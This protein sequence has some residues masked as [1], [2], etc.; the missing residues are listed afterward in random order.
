MK[1]ELILLASYVTSK[2]GTLNLLDLKLFPTRCR[3]TKQLK[4]S[5][6]ASKVNH[7]EQI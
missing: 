5:I 1:G 7:L 6:E 4:E 2:K 3:A